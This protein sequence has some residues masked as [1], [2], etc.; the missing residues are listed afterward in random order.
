MLFDR[1]EDARSLAQVVVETVRESLL[2]LDHTLTILVAGASF[3]KSFQIDPRDT[4][5]R[6]RFALDKWR[7]GYSGPAC[8]GK[9]SWWTSR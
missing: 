5:D 1:I 2:V 8:C 7:L 6:Q 3:H 4:P 9:V